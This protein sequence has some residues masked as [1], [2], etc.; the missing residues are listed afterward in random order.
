[1]YKTILHEA[2]YST[3]TTT[4]QT[5]E[6]STILKLN[7]ALLVR[8]LSF[9]SR[10]YFH[11]EQGSLRTYDNHVKVQLLTTLTRWGVTVIC[12]LLNFTEVDNVYLQAR[13][14]FKI[15]HSGCTQVGVRVQLNI[16]KIR[17]MCTRKI[18]YKRLIRKKLRN[19]VWSLIYVHVNLLRTFGD[20]WPFNLFT[21]FLGL[22]FVAAKCRPCFW[23][24]HGIWHVS[25]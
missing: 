10:L 12:I 3:T 25:Y 21:E 13:Q 22:L 19:V 14:L 7:I 15:I 2:L 23:K 1:M 4:T 24:R 16:P 8:K 18:V 17:Y 5:I 11:L 6:Q 9:F 20:S